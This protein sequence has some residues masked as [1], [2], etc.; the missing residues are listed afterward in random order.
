MLKHCW[1]LL[2]KFRQQLSFLN[3][4][5]KKWNRSQEFCSVVLDV[6]NAFARCHYGSRHVRRPCRRSRG[7]GSWRS[8]RRA[9][10]RPARTAAWFSTRTWSWTTRARSSSSCRWS[11][12]SAVW[13]R[14][15]AARTSARTAIRPTP[16]WRR[17]WVS[18]TWR[19]QTRRIS[20]TTASSYKLHSDRRT[21]TS[22]PPASMR[23]FQLTFLILSS[24]PRRL[25]TCTTCRP[26]RMFI[27]YVCVRSLL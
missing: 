8:T 11:T 24:L 6:V 19:H 17:N 21:R 1:L 25:I 9:S 10:R 23:Q 3:C 15:P 14:S 26:L 4:R 2:I 22:P 27:T 13:W 5:N 12:T 16:R 18:P 20:S 7:S